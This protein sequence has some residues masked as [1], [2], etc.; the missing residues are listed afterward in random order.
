M[1]ISWKRGTL[2]TLVER[3]YLICSTIRLLEQELTHFRTVF[4][5]TNCYP[6]W[7]INQAFEQIKF[8]QRDPVSNS[9]V[10]NENEAT[11]T[12][13]RAVFVKHNYASQTVSLWKK[14]LP[15]YWQH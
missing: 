11:Q 15:R 3:A 2:K 10:S 9:N 4:I 8:T 13:R 6:N 5:N 1:L 7:I 14:C 12:S